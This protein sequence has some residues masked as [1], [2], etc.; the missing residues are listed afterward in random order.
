[1]IPVNKEIFKPELKPLEIKKEKFTFFSPQRM[2]R[3][4]GTDL[5]WKAL[6]LCKSDFEI[7]QVDWY[8]VSTNEELEIKKG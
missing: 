7:I 6:P 8:D 5:I 1:M 4:K 3:P 2:G